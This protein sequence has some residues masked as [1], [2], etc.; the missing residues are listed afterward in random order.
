MDTPVKKNGIEIV[1]GK[2][3]VE[4]P[5]VVKVGRERIEAKNPIIAG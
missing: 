2:A 5:N 1:R 4:S 3:L